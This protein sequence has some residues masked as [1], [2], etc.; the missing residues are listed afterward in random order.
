MVAATNRHDGLHTL[1]RPRRRAIAAIR[2]SKERDGM[3]SPDVQRHAIEQYA[4]REGIDVT[5]WIEG[6]DESGSQARSAWW[7]RLDYAIGQIESGQADVILVWKFSRV[8]R[9]RVRWAVALDRVDT[10]GG[11]IESATEQADATPSGRLQRGMMGEFN[12]YQAELIGESW[13]EA[14]ERRVRRGL[15]PTG[16]HRFGYR[17]EQHAPTCAPGCERPKAH[18]AYAPDPETGPL[19]AELYRLF[20]AGWGFARLA[21]WLTDKAATPT[22]K[23]WSRPGVSSMLDSGFGAGLLA[24]SEVVGG[25][26]R[27]PMPWL[28]RYSPGAHEAVIDDPTWRA[29]VSQREVRHGG[30]ERGPTSP[31]LLSGLV[32]CGD[33]GGAMHGKR[34]NGRAS[35]TCTRGERTPSMRKVSIVAWRADEIAERWIFALAEDVNAQLRAASTRTAVRTD[36]EAFAR[37]ARARIQ[38]GTDRLAALAI[39][40]ADGVLSDAAYAAAVESIQTD[41]E[42]ASGILRAATPNPVEEQAAVEV[43]RD[44][45]SLWPTLTVEQRNLLLRPLLAFVEVA[46][47]RHRGDKGDRCEAVAKW[48]DRARS[49]VM[50]AD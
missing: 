18:G 27:A 32:R 11:S 34:E 12:A 29:Y 13:R 48:D 43:P 28:R 38:K 17:Q 41:I 24:H 21:T 1:T 47:A 50:E 20:L 22:G 26:R 35:Y 45:A 10:A 49:V 39:K 36:T 44:L 25:T 33:C 14:H 46:P 15:P 4:A 23:P 31:Y 16:G 7:P 37:R 6:L 5:E 3:T 2:V 19:L 9:S 42:A 8:G 30:R 40:L